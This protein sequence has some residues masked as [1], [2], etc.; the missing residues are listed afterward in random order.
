M[1]TE[2]QH[3]KS[4]LAPT[5]RVVSFKTEKGFAATEVNLQNVSTE[6]HSNQGE[7]MEESANHFG[8]FSF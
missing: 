6:A 1:K 2:T 8:S 4:Y 7:Q 3:K 5:W